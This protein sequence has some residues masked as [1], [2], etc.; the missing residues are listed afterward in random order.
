MRLKDKLEYEVSDVI[1]RQLRESFSN[2]IPDKVN[3]ELTE[4]ARLQGQQD[5]IRFLQQIKDRIKDNLP[6]ED[7]FN[8]RYNFNR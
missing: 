6:L 8:S 2:A 4:V 7:I 5:V 1:M 3:I